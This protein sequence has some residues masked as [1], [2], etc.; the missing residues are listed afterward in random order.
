MCINSCVA[1]TGPFKALEV[2]PVCDEPRFDA[3]NRPRQVFLTIPIGPQLQ[4]LRRNKDKAMALRYRTLHTEALILELADNNG[5]PKGYSDFF[6]GSQYMDAFER[7]LIKEDDIVLMLSLDSAQLFASKHSDC[8]MCIWVVFDHSPDVRYKKPYVLPV[9]TIPGPNPPRV[10]DSFLYRSLQHLAALQKDSLVIWD[11]SKDANVPSNPFFALA[12][13][14][15]PGLTHLNGLVG[16]MGKNGCRMYCSVC[17]RRKPRDSHYYPALLKPLPPYNVEGCNH[18][19]ADFDDPNIFMPSVGKYQDHLHLLVSSRNE[20]KYKE[21]RLNTG[22]VKPSIF[23]GLDQNHCFPVPLCF[24]SDIM[25]H[26]SLNIPDLLIP[27]WRGTFDCS[28]TDK[29]S[30]WDWVALTGETWI[31]HGRAVAAATPYLPGSF[32]RPPRDPALKISSG[33]KAWEFLMYMYGL[34]PGVFYGIL[35]TPYYENF[36]DLIYGM[37]IINQHKISVAQLLQADDALKRFARDFKKIYYQRRTD[38]IHF[39]RQSIH[40]CFHLAWEVTRVGVTYR[41]TGA[42]SAHSTSLPHAPAR[43]IPPSLASASAEDCASH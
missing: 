32:D 10:M 29:R 11:A 28:A 39:V 41:N 23:L 27:L 43:T 21:N 9:F 17:G 20:T 7:G 15:G 26:C 3:G 16:H 30:T 2:C 13:A 42:T 6:D 36:C 31:K 1:Y 5:L 12:T 38:R 14:D 35:P 18:P 24:G 40:L 34:G 25:H 8:W 22:I 37:R 19:D 4:A 33:Y